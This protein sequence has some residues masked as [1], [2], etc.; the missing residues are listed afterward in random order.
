MFDGELEVE[1]GLVIGGPHQLQLAVA[2]QRLDGGVE[3][4]DRL[5]ALEY[6]GAQWVLDGRI[7]GIQVGD[8]RR[9]AGGEQVAVALDDGENVFA[10]Y[11]H[12][13]GRYLPNAASNCWVPVTGRS[14]T[15]P[16]HT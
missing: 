1:R 9:G 10:G 15:V 2:I 13:P 7:V 4:L 12:T 5:A 16:R 6:V 3:A 8:L 11:G 14:Q